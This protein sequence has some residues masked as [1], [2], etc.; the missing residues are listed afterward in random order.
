MSGA[1]IQSRI[2]AGLKRAN[3]RTGDGTNLIILNQKVTSAGNPVTPG[4]TTVTQIT[5]IDAILTSYTNAQI[6]NDLIIKGDKKLISNSDTL[7]TVNDEILVN[8]ITHI[9]VDTDSKNPSNVPLV[10]ISQLRLQ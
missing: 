10:Y 9:V 1:D 5:L 4:V 3:V 8:G 6:D 2:K 7:I